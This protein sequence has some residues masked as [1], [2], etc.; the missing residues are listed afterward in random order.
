MNE[1]QQVIVVLVLLVMHCLLVG[2]LFGTVPAQAL[3]GTFVESK[4][5]SLKNDR[6]IPVPIF[7][8][9]LKKKKRLGGK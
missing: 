3:T 2:W 5:E 6:R 9:L 8:T 4:Y 1:Q 7:S